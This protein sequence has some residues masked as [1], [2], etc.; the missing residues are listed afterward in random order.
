MTRVVGEKDALARERKAVAPRHLHA[1]DQPRAAGD[2][3]AEGRQVHRALTSA[4]MRSVRRTSVTS[5]PIATITSA[6]ATTWPR[7]PSSGSKTASTHA[8]VITAMRCGLAIGPMK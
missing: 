7:Q 4:T 5:D 1:A 2:D 8:T 3:A 6:S